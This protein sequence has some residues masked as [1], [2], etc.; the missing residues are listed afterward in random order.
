[1][2]LWMLSSLARPAHPLLRRAA[3]S[4]RLPSAGLA[5]TMSSISA[6]SPMIANDDRGWPVARVRSTFVDFFAAQHGHTAFPSS[7]VVPYDDPTLLFANAG[8]NQFKPIFLGQA[9]STT[10]TLLV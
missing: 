10:Y 6:N 7:P 5:R 2:L 1:M 3:F 4:R 9:K 8:M